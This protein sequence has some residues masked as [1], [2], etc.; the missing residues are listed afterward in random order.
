M[1]GVQTVKAIVSDTF[2]RTAAAGSWGAADVGGTWAISAATAPASGASVAGGV[3]LLAVPTSGGALLA[4]LAS[5]GRD[6]ELSGSVGYSALPVGGNAEFRHRARSSQSGIAAATGS[7]YG[8]SLSLNTT[9][10]VAVV[11]QKVTGGSSGTLTNLAAGTGVAGYTVGQRVRYRARIRG[12]NPTIL[13]ARAWLDGTAEPIGWTVSTTDTEATL[14]ARNSFVGANVVVTG[15]GAVTVSV[16]DYTIASLEPATLVVNE[17]A[18]ELDFGGGTIVELECDANAL[19][20]TPSTE[21]IDLGT[22]CEPT[23]T[24]QGRTTFTAVLSLLWSPSLY[25]KLA[26]H[27][28]QTATL[29]FY[30]DPADTSRYITFQT[31]YASVPWGRFEVGQ[32]VDVELALAVLSTPDYVGELP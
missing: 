21:D 17:A 6:V 20:I 15:T 24:D 14:Q 8:V 18:V 9:G 19:E 2:T 22:F 31:R 4:Q 27:E 26:G 7:W 11:L 13:E 12:A 10:G 1:S 16:D 29:R 23:A 28:G 32:R 30:P 3:G 5:G 25:T